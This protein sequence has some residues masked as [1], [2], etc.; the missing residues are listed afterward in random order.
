MVITEEEQYFYGRQDAIAQY[1][2]HNYNP[3]WSEYESSGVPYERH[4]LREILSKPELQKFKVYVFS[5]N[6]FISEKYKQSIDKLLKNKG[7]RLVWVYNSG[8]ISEKGMLAAN[9]T[10]ITGINILTNEKDSRFTPINIDGAPYTKD[11]YPFCSGVAMW[12][13]IWNDNGVQTFWV[14]DDLAT[15]ITKYTE[16]GR[17]S[18]AVKDFGS[19]KS[20]YI[21]AGQGLSAPMLNN[22]AKEAGAY[23]AAPAG[24]QLDMNADFASVHGIKYM[25]NYY[26]ELPKGKSKIL[27]AETKTVLARNIKRYT[28]PVD[29]YKTY[30]FLFE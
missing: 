7:R 2:N 12:N 18:S 21:G 1:D 14:E 20:I 9:L 13:A 25:Q 3:Q 30:W 17:V 4:Y 29:V 16:N 24:E 15:P 10:Q 6:T 8:Y 19:W 22:I 27:D 26:L 5:Q 23:I 11:A 28:F